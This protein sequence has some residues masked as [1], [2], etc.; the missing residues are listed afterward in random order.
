MIIKIALI[1]NGNLAFHL[2]KRLKETGNP[3]AGLVVRDKKNAGEF[4]ALLN[5]NAVITTQKDLSLFNWDI[6]LLAVSDS[7]IPQIVREYKLPQ[8][9]TVLHCA[10]SRSIGVFQGTDIE[11]YGVLYPLQTFSKGKHVQFENIP[12]YIEGS[13]ANVENEIRQFGESLSP[14]VSVLNSEQRLKLHMAA[15]IACNFSNALYS[16]AQSQLNEIGL[17]FEVL[18]ALVSETTE[19]AIAIGP[20]KAQTGPAARKDQEVIDKHLEVLESRPEIKSIYQ[21]LTNLI[22][23]SHKDD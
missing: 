13:S 2:A 23:N 11:K 21:Q 16:V 20:D 8:N 19:K 4:E 1:G 9:A 6:V 5:S 15:V 3:I 14:N 12:I 18:A 17:N 22:G 10:G 7:A